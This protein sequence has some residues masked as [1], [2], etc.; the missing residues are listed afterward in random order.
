MSL[1]DILALSDT[2]FNRIYKERLYKLREDISKIKARFKKK[3]KSLSANKKLI[4]S[5]IDGSKNSVII[6]ENG[7]RAQ[8]SKGCRKHGLKHI[9]LRHFCEECEGKI[10]AMD[11]ISIE[12]FFKDGNE[13]HASDNK[14]VYNYEKN[15]DEKFRLLTFKDINLE[16]ILSVYRLDRHS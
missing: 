4:I 15:S 2:E 16:G 3:N 11:I 10:S 6:Y 12:R 8:F 1:D 7:I 9:L 13:H 14:R 5:M